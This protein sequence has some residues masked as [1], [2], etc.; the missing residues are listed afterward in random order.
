MILPCSPMSMEKDT[1]NNFSIG[2]GEQGRNMP[3]R[4]SHNMK[5]FPQVS[6]NTDTTINFNETTMRN[7][8]AF[9]RLSSQL[10]PAI[11]DSNAAN[12]QYILK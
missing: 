4:L 3:N 12:Q 10:Q 5:S 2:M 9:S 11:M 8:L 1:D 6:T 7:F